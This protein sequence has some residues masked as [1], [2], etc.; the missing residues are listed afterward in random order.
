V[1]PLPGAALPAHRVDAAGKS[2][3]DWR[4]VAGLTLPLMANSSL[5]AV[6]S[7][8]D[9]YFVG[10]ISTSAVAGMGSIYWFAFFFILLAGGVGLAVQTLVAQAEGGGRRSR[11]SRAVWIA[12]WGALVT[13][14][15]FVGIAYLGRS[16]LAPFD[17]GAD[18]EHQAIRFWQPRM[19]GAP[20]G[21]A[22][23]AVLGFFNGISRTR[24]TLL[25]TGFVAIVNALLNDLFI[26]RFHWGVAGSA[27]ATN[28]SM[29]S[30]VAVG[31]ALLL[32]G[33]VRRRYRSQLT[34]RFSAAAVAR[35]FRIGLPMG[36]LGAADI[37]GISL[38]QVMQVGLSN[39]EGA[40]TQIVMMLTSVAYLPG[41]GLALAGTTLVGQ[42]IGAG[43]RAWARH[44]GNVIIAANVAFMG[45]LGVLLALSGPWIFPAFVNPADP[46]APRVI[47]LGVQILWIAAGYQ[48]FDG[49]NLGSGFCLRGAG[50]ATVPAGLALLLSWGLFLPLAHMLSFAPGQGWVDVL[51]QFGYGTRG[52]WVAMLIYVCALGTALYLRWRSG[53]WERIRL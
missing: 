49:L 30:G 15:F 40:A 45:F 36:F 50:D 52:G 6:I 44:L 33:D 21:V 51:P 47:A 22:L 3:I 18:V 19:F 25:T 8:T 38:F 35:Q 20:L 26:F 1:P 11:A 14:P 34:W 23:W 43:D 48:L 41:V 10:Q 32:S 4:A 7:L 31:I 46:E 27:W 5:Q 2:R 28:V 24:I 42:A 12:L 13:L 53:A 9:T 29:L 16:F 17:L 37:L 39:A